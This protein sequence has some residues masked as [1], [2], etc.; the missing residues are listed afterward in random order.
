MS[1]NHL[2]SN[3]LPRLCGGTGHH[4]CCDGR[5]SPCLWE[6][7]PEVQY[8]AQPHRTSLCRIGASHLTTKSRRR[9]EQ[10]QTQRNILAGR[11]FGG[12]G[13]TTKT[14]WTVMTLSCAQRRRWKSSFRLTGGLPRRRRRRSEKACQLSSP[15]CESKGNQKQKPASSEGRG[16]HSA[17]HQSPTLLGK[18][19]TR[20]PHPRAISRGRKR[21]ASSTCGDQ[22]EL[23]KKK[24]DRR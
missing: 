18:D 23:K 14:H 1:H 6:P 7:H 13:G 3:S 17:T 22:Q 8:P 11:G 21:Y 16:G 15:R 12:G 9:C 5:S 19:S 2:S 10:Q 4:A 24:Y 20:V